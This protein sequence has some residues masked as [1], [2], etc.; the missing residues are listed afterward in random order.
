MKT[1]G[2]FLVTSLLLALIF[3]K[4]CSSGIPKSLPASVGPN[5]ESNILALLGDKSIIAVYKWNVS[6]EPDQN[7]MLCVVRRSK[8][9]AE[10]S[11]GATQLA[12]YDS[13]AKIIYQDSFASLNAFY[14]ID[15]LRTGTSQLAVEVDHG[16]SGTYFLELLVYR[17]GKV[18]NLLNPT[19]SEFNAL[20]E[21]KPQFRK[22]VNPAA[23]PFEI[24]LTRG[25]GLAS[26]VE[27]V[28]SVYRY[29]NGK[30]G[31]VGHYLQRDLDDFAETRLKK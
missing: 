30:Y 26:P 20:A 25:V 11:D 17:D 28:T 27:K 29:Q 24:R 21:I 16:G 31:L 9:D 13:A 15:A 23:E 22:G 5:A 2:V 14:P 3:G 18:L 4:A 6:E 12:I 19:Q 8:H 7:V 1:L 10:T